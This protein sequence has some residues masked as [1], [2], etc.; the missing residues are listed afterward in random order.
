MSKLALPTRKRLELDDASSTVTYVGEA[1]FG[2]VASDANWRIFKLT[3]S[4]T[5]LSLTWA[6][7]ND[8]FDNVWANRASLSYS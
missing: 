6:D 2:A 5:V 8:N 7:G 4:G 1:P 3:S